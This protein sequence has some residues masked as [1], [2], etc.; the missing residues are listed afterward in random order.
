M[1]TIKQTLNL[2]HQANL[3]DEI[4]E[5]SLGEGDEVTVLKEWADSFLCKNLDGLLF[6][7]PKESV[8]A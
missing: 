1:A 4:E 5:F 6:N 2:K 8:E 3:G 7:I